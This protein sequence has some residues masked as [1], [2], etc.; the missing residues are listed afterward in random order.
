MRIPYLVVPADLNYR[1]LT[2]K[3]TASNDSQS[4]FWSFSGYGKLGIVCGV[5]RVMWKI[6]ALING[7]LCKINAGNCMTCMRLWRKI[8]R[9]LCQ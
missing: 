1:P 4:Q 6:A 2:V 9:D 5:K 3:Y 8:L 7:N